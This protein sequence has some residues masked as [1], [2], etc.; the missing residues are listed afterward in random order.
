MSS[1]LV[2]KPNLKKKRF[3]APLYQWKPSTPTYSCQCF[4]IVRY[5]CLYTAKGSSWYEVFKYVI[6]YLK[7]LRCNIGTLW[8]EGLGL[9]IRKRNPCG[10]TVCYLHSNSRYKKIQCFVLPSSCKSI[11]NRHFQLWTKP[12]TGLKWGCV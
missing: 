8:L 2:V 9:Y 3:C 4:I 1:K 10:P 7:V 12:E 11:K 5:L 6:K